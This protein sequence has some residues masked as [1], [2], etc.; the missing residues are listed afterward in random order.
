MLDMAKTLGERIRLYRVRKG[1]TQDSL[2]EIA[3]SHGKYIGQLER[4]EK[5]A[6]IESIAK[7]A[8]ALDLPLEVLFENLTTGET[9]NEIPRKCYNLLTAMNE[10]E[11]TVMLE[12]I[13]KAVD[14]KSI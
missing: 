1:L 14:F 12:L 9:K 13:Q 7:I 6:T 8:K 2:A 4:G 10:K 5:N 3:D 11:Q